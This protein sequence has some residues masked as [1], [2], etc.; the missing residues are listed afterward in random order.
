MV[1]R[2]WADL[3]DSCPSFGRPQPYFL[4]RSGI[5]NTS[6]ADEGSHWVVRT[7]ECI[8]WLTPPSDLS[9]GKPYLS[10]YPFSGFWRTASLAEH[11]GGLLNRILISYATDLDVDAMHR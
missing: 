6:S 8:A 11:R 3:A 2:P 5:T 1:N 9:M 10:G 4:L 7:R